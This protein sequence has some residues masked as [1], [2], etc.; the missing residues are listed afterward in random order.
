MISD[1]LFV[2]QAIR[3]FTRQDQDIAQL[4]Q[5][6]SS[7]VNDPRVSSDP[8]RAMELSALRDV[9]SDLATQT[10]I[11]RIVADRLAFSDA[12]LAEVSEGVRELYL[13]TLQAG[14]D[15]LTSEAHMALRVKAETLRNTL[16]A[17]ANSSDQQGRPLFS[18]TSPGPAFVAAA[19]GVAYQGDATAPAVQMGRSTRLETGLTGAQVFGEDRESVFALLD[20]IVSSLSEPMISARDTVQAVGRAQLDLAEK[21][22]GKITLTLK[23][24]LG[25]AQVSLMLGS[26]M[27]AD[28]VAAINAASAQTGI[29]AFLPSDGSGIHLRASGP[30]AL[31]DQ[32]GPADSPADGPVPQPLLRLSQLQT[33]E[34]PAGT[35]QALR[36]AHMSSQTLIARSSGKVEHLAEMRAATG[37]LARAVENR[38]ER[39][40]ETRLAL[41]QA[42]SRLQDVNVAETITRLQTLLLNQQAGQQS[43]I[44]ITGRSL[45][46]YLG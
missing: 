2:Q 45:F 17:A 24:P 13:I 10:Q 20:D 39:L 19:Q 22:E 43:F 11:G 18:G 7:G 5:Q 34:H 37:A 8:A 28:Q 15:T 41:D 25:S 31:S 46:D 33:T 35:A 12:A 36:P 30:I 44:K 3:G 26:D 21:P 27:Q 38:L 1:A 40:A 23:G 42:V 14:N 32:Q 6:L 4:Q 29:E 16:L 9:S